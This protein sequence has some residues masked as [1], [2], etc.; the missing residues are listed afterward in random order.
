MKKYDCSCI[1]RICIDYLVL[2][3]KYPEIDTKLPLLKYKTCLGG[4]AT[5]AAIVLSYLGVKTSLLT[6]V[7]KDDN[8]I[9]VKKL[10][11]QHKK[12]KTFFVVK[13]ELKTPVAFI[14]VDKTTA[15]R[16]IVYEKVSTKNKCLYPQELLTKIIKQSKFILFDHQSSKDIY[17]LKE[18]FNKYNT[19]L[20]MDAERNDK[21]MFKMLKYINYFVCSSELAKDL[22][23]NI[24][25]L[26]KKF[27][28]LGPQIVCCTLGK[29]GAVA[30]CKENPNKFYYSK[31]PKVKSI[32]TTGAGDVFHAGFMY[33]LIKGWRIKEILSFANKLA[34]LS[35]KYIGGSSFLNKEKYNL[36]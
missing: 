9:L 5:T 19:K 14:F 16:T 28:S 1:G 6:T 10:I 15:T 22:N 17:I 31:P 4:Q 26:L 18:L 34:A 8:F 11:K 23:L 3:E 27:I 30:V 13:K 25:Q 21:Y 12:L 7:G 20:M 36:F 29:D 33:G 35:T 32:D 24:K 2:V